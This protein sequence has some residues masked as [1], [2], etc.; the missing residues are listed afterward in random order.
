MPM[1][2]PLYEALGGNRQTNMMGDLQRF[3]QQM[4][5]KN[6]REEIHRMLQSGSITQEQLNFAQQRA[7][8]IMNTLGMMKR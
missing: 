5:G 4:Q 3:V 2:N 1:S 6:P 7:Q 8:Q